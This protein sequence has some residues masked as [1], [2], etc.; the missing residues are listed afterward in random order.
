MSL[1]KALDFELRAW[2]LALQLQKELT[3]P[4]SQ[5]HQLP[6][7]NGRDLVSNTL[8]GKMCP[9]TL[10]KDPRASAVHTTAHGQKQLMWLLVELGTQTTLKNVLGVGNGE[11]SVKA[12]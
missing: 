11:I 12:N 10:P 4:S 1:G 8:R 9:L 5:A 2:G 3:W 7:L 6:H